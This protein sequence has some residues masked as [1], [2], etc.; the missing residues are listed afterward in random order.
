MRPMFARFVGLHGASFVRTEHTIW[1]NA[2]GTSA[3]K[4]LAYKTKHKFVAYSNYRL[5]LSA[6]L[7]PDGI[8]VMP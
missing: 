7:L 4:P 5:I 6:S 3:A 2:H 8:A 1:L